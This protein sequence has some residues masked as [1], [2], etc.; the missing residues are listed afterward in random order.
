MAGGII[1]SILFIWMCVHIYIRSK[2]DKRAA[3]ETLKKQVKEAEDLNSQLKDFAM[4]L[5]RENN[6]IGFVYSQIE[7]EGGGLYHHDYEPDIQAVLGILS[8]YHISSNKS[9]Q[10]YYKLSK[11]DDLQSSISMFKLERN[12]IYFEVRKQ[13]LDLPEG[14]T[15]K[16]R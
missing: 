6:K 2:E 7:I 14:K 11:I 3:V 15:Y 5:A 13:V 8:K 12:K 1:L 10:V 16:Y 9:S 4:N